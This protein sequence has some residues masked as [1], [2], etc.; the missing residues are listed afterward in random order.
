M[1]FCRVP[2]HLINA[3][4]AYRPF[5]GHTKC[6]WQAP[7]WLRWIAVSPDHHIFL[8][9]TCHH[10]VYV[11][12]TDG[13]LLRKWGSRGNEAGQFD[14]PNGIAVTPG[15]EVVIC[16]SWNHRLQ[17]FSLDGTLVRMW[18]SE[19]PGDGQLRFPHAVAVTQ[20]DQVV[21]TE[22]NSPHIQVFRVSDA[23]F[24]CK[25][26]AQD[27]T[28]LASSNLVAVCVSSTGLVCSAA[29]HFLFDI[30]AGIGS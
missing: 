25:W 23:A 30:D 2:A 27:S 15:G 18:G 6:S 26:N 16:D 12:Q 9:A 17:V 5:R 13:V 1:A 11:Y 7:V 4:R 14:Y 10:C 22:C 21:V 8:S 19:G 28:D 24:V 3:I 29:G 20:N